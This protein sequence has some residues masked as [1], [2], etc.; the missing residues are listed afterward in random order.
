MT[1]AVYRPENI[2]GSTE[3]SWLELNPF[4]TQNYTHTHILTDG[5]Y[6]NYI[7]EHTTKIMIQCLINS[8]EDDVVG[9]PGLF[10]SVE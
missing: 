9:G 7:K 4:C 6:T 3:G 10:T 2:M 5:S 8:S 1:R